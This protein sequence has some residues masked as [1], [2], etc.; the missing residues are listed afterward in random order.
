[1]TRRDEKVIEALVK[2]AR[3]IML[4]GV[5]EWRY[6]RDSCIAACRIGALSL[7]HFNVQARVI[8][9][10]YIIL[11]AA[12]IT[13]VNETKHVPEDASELRDDAHSLAIGVD[14]ND[15]DNMGHFALACGPRLLVDL[16]IDQVSRP[17]RGL[18]FDQP[19]V[20]SMPAG[21]QSSDER[22]WTH[23]EAYSFAARAEPQ[24][25]N[26][27]RSRDWTLRSRYEPFVRAVIA[28]MER[29]GAR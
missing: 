22:H 25:K 11:N 13:Q 8:G 14:W 10:S 29:E 7:H 12:Y 28:A 2:V 9:V 3:P 6:G 26:F 19:L 17:D 15:T 20:A 5:G 1:M 23:T 24:N 18:V 4:R 16:T 27:V 21:W